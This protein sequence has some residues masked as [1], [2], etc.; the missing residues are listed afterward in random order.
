[1]GKHGG[2]THKDTT[3]HDSTA[4][5]GSHKQVSIKEI[6]VVI[7]SNT[8]NTSKSRVDGRGEKKEVCNHC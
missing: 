2:L 1:M 5:H 3:S 6:K 7:V 4:A 8:S